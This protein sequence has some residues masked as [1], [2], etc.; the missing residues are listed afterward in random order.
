MSR[1]LES[2]HVPFFIPLGCQDPFVCHCYG[3]TKER[4]LH[5]LVL[6]SG[7]VVLNLCEIGL[8]SPRIVFRIPKSVWVPYCRVAFCCKLT[9][10]NCVL[11]VSVFVCLCACFIWLLRPDSLQDTLLSCDM[12]WSYHASPGVGILLL[13]VG[14]VDMYGIGVI[15]LNSPFIRLFSD[16]I[17]R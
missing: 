4:W 9:H 5:F 15:Q 13:F 8:H 7:N 1:F 16:S 6:C 3:C 17:T 10:V 2:L 12:V 14:K 11:W